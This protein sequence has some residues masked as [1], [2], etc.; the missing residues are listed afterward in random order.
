MT[1]KSKTPDT[2]SQDFA[3]R[4]AVV[5]KNQAAILDCL[6]SMSAA[7]QKLADDVASALPTG[8]AIRPVK[9]PKK[10]A[11]IVEADSGPPLIDVVWDAFEFNADAYAFWHYPHAALSG[12]SPKEVASDPA[13]AAIIRDLIAEIRGTK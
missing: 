11:A 1:S 7:L 12:K 10:A 9:V 6:A 13:S 5:E 3:A 8:S 2:V 4:L